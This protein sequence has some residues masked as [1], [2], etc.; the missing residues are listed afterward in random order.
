MP[1]TLTRTVSGLVFRDEFADLTNW[2]LHGATEWTAETGIPQFT[3][4]PH[5]HL[6]LG[7]AGSGGESHNLREPLAIQINAG[8]LHVY[9]DGAAGDGSVWTP[10]LS[11][12]TDGGVTWDRRG[13]LSITPTDG[14]EEYSPSYLFQWSGQ[15]YFY[16]STSDARTTD[17]Y[18]TPSPPYY[19]YLL[20]TTASVPDENATWTKVSNNDPALPG[21]GLVEFAP[22]VS[23]VDNG[24]GTFAAWVSVSDGTSWQ[25][26][27]ATSSSRLGPWAFSTA[28]H[29]PAGVALALN[30]PE[31]PRLLCYSSALGRYVM[32]ATAAP[33]PGGTLWFADTLAGFGTSGHVL[34]ARVFSAGDGV[35]GSQFNFWSPIYD[36]TGTPGDGESDGAVGVIAAIALPSDRNYYGFQLYAGQL[37]AHPTCARFVGSADRVITAAPSLP[38]A[39]VAEVVLELASAAGNTGFLFALSNPSGDIN[40]VTA[41]YADCSA[42]TSVVLYK[43]VAGS[44]TALQTLAVGPAGFSPDSLNG[45]HRRFRVAWDGTTI[46][47]SVAG[48]V[49]DAVVPTGPLVGTGIGIRAGNGLNDGRVRGLSIYKSDTVT[50]SGLPAGATVALCGANG[51]PAVVGTADG[52]G[53]L[54]LVHSHYPLY[55]GRVNGVLLT[56]ATGVIWGGDS[57][58][59]A[60]PSGLLNRRRRLAS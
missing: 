27:V 54:S 5:D 44:Y 1:A 2:D 14:H 42:S 55:G 29:L 20:T 38:S 36:T 23:I 40:A 60:A 9:Y 33:N 37:D 56:P 26:G 57:Y 48:V 53:N 39:W 45:I 8:T 24:G 22:I 12:S 43:A 46:H 13:P 11:V 15:W 34:C 10:R 52:S 21:G 31:N 47:L 49:G 41:Y 7:V 25:M 59:F 19:N 58:T 4:H 17:A 28:A 16:F 3:Y 35:A 51:L 50:L 18:G 32:G 30:Q 6:M